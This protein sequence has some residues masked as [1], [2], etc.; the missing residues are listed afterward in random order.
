[1]KTPSQL[2]L[3]TLGKP[4]LEELWQDVSKWNGVNERV[5]R[6]NNPLV[7]LSTMMFCVIFVH[8]SCMSILE[9]SIQTADRSSKESYQALVD[10]SVD[11]VLVFVMCAI[12]S[13]ANSS[14]V[15]IQQEL[16]GRNPGKV[17]VLVSLALTRTAKFSLA[18]S[19]GFLASC[20][21]AFFLGGTTGCLLWG[22]ARLAFSWTLS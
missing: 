20:G 16:G 17:E 15:A 11:L 7:E 4:D 19:W 8:M 6:M 9:Y 13:G 18:L 21:L 14:H 10:T 12:V 22:L 1:M 5:Q 3:I 2:L